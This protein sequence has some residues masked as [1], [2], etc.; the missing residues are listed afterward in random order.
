MPSRLLSISTSKLSDSGS[1]DAVLDLPDDYAA[2]I[3]RIVTKFSIL[4]HA[5]S[6]SNYLLLSI[7]REIGRI[8]VRSPRAS[9]LV[10]LTSELLSAK[11][12][13][14]ATDLPKLI[15]AIKGIQTDRDIFAHG[16]WTHNLNGHLCVNITSGTWRASDESVKRRRRP[17]A[18]EI[19]IAQMKEVQSDIISALNRVEILIRECSAVSGSPLSGLR[20]NYAPRRPSQ[21][22]QKE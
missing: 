2:E 22:P 20:P 16:L 4:E 21:G 3:G 12:F 10:Q 19:S 8:S 7:D 13:A 11:G 5:C 1:S 9:E 15:S 17:T 14:V 18:V 6:I